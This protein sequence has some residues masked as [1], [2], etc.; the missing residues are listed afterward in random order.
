MGG[1]RATSSGNGAELDPR[2]VCSCQAG[3]E[4][5]ADARL[6]LRRSRVTNP[7]PICDPETG[8]GRGQKPQGCIRG[9]GRGP[10]NN[11]KGLTPI[12]DPFIHPG[13]PGQG[14]TR[15]TRPHQ[16]LRSLGAASLRQRKGSQGRGPP[17]TAHLGRASCPPPSWETWGWVG[18]PASEVASTGARCGTVVLIRPW[19]AGQASRAAF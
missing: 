4:D 6:R 19:K 16:G 14:A 3:E 12:R 13:S 9:V 15:V 18:G 5:V 7:A 2:E 1:I 8:G 10:H 17:T 11:R